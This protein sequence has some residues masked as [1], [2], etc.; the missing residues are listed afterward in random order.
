[1]NTLDLIRLLADGKFHSGQAIASQFSVSRTAVWKTIQNMSRWGIQ[2]DSVRGRGYRL[3]PVI[4]LLERDKIYSNLSP[5]SC[6]LIE[7]IIVLQVVDSTNEYLKEVAGRTQFAQS[8]RMAK[9]AVCLSEYQLQGRGRRGKAWHSP[10]GLNVLMSVSWRF[11]SLPAQVN[12]LSLILGVALINALSVLGIEGLKLKWPNDL[13]WQ[14]RKLAG[15]LLE[16][17]GEGQG[18]LYAIAGIG[19]NLEPGV[20]NQKIDQPW[21]SLSEIQEEGNV[22]RNQVVSAIL[23]SVCDAFVTFDTE[24]A[25]SYIEQWQKYDLSYGHEVSIMLPNQVVTGVSRGIDS[26]GRLQLDTRS[27]LQSFISGE[28]SLRVAL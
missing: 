26:Q 23:D 9:A 10:F 25:G 24:G 8:V 22:S 27:G 5:G 2:I 19:L 3:R 6:D 21:V 1:M 18:P 13:Y 14:K 20:D 17:F 12:T 16:L 15:I 7:E 4:E 11:E 28:V